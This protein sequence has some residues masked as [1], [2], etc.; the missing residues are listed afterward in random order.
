MTLLTTVTNMGLAMREMATPTGFEPVISAVTGRR[1][2]PLHH[3][4]DEPLGMRTPA[5]N[6][7][8]HQL[9]SKPFALRAEG[10]QTS[11]LN[12]RPQAQLLRSR[13]AAVQSV[14]G[15]VLLPAATRLPDEAAP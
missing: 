2:R 4:A 5:G 9:D 6:P 13:Q 7:E 15:G 3:G 10:I 1:V 14:R 11:V 8:A 12:I